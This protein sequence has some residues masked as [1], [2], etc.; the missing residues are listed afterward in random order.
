MNFLWLFS[1]GQLHKNSS[2]MKTKIK[3]AVANRKPRNINCDT[4]IIRIQIRRSLL[5]TFEPSHDFLRWSRESERLG[6]QF[7]N[8]GADSL[9]TLKILRLWQH[10]NEHIKHVFLLLDSSA[11][12]LLCFFFKIRTFMS[13]ILETENKFQHRWW[14]N[15]YAG[16]ASICHFCFQVTET[17]QR[18]STLALV[19]NSVFIQAVYV[20]GK[21]KRRIA[22]PRRLQIKWQRPSLYLPSP[23]YTLIQDLKW[24]FFL[25]CKWFAC[26]CTYKQY[27]WTC[28]CEASRLGTVF[29]HH[30]GF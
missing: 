3:V 23:I 29:F 8:Y 6:E 10:P 24:F 21:L 26:S 4:L 25:P 12:T 1:Y 2:F 28:S 27:R 5:L 19:R 18:Q 16:T 9:L 11:Y 17:F 13:K 14:K 7:F 20:C 15:D 22:L 30:L